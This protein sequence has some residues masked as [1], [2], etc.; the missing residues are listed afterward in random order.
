VFDDDDFDAPLADLDPETVAAFDGAAAE[1]FADRKARLTRVLVDG[2]TGVLYE[3]LALFAEPL[4]ALYDLDAADAFRLRTEPEAVADDTVA[5]LETARVL[6]AFFSLP[7]PD[8]A[9]KRS[10]LAA[11]LVGE[12]PSEE[13]WMGLDGLLGSVEVHWQ[14][15]L[16][17]EIEMAQQT[18]H[19]TLGFDDLLHHPAFRVGTEEDD[20]THA[21]FGPDGLSETEAR[22][23]FA[24][25]LLESDAVMTDPD[26]FE[27]ALARADE[28]WDLARSGGDPDAYSTSFAEADRARVADEARTMVARFRELFPEHAA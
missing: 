22:A 2:E 12:D 4:F 28:Y 18:G 10:A 6:W 5:L 3:S 9:H 17:E 21:G 1:A 23:R 24:Q 27:D 26:A 15:M 11:Q 19:P 8:R 14:A 7:A 20:A 25:P 13:D 16:P